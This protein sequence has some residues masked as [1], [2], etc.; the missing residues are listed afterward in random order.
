MTN[1]KK[2]MNINETQARLANGWWILDGCGWGE[3]RLYRT[4]EDGKNSVQR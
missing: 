2:T 1:G 3:L 4:Q